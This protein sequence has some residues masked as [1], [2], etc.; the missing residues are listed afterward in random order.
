MPRRGHKVNAETLD[1]VDRIVERHDFHFASVARTGVHL[2]DGERTPQRLVD[3]FADLAA[4]L[5]RR[6]LRLILGN[7]VMVS[8]I[9]IQAVVRRVDQAGANVRGE[10]ELRGDAHRAIGCCVGALAA[11]DA[12]AVIDGDAA[13]ACVAVAEHDGPGG[14]KRRRCWNA[15]RI[16]GGSF[17]W[18]STRTRTGR[19]TCGSKRSP[20]HIETCAWWATTTSRSI[21]GAAPTFATF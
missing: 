15:T 9:G 21:P 4:R 1:I 17:T 3:C 8:P 20:P 5:F 14:T 16:A 19:N 7:Q 2:A 12:E 6:D 13:M 11:E 10:F 18:T